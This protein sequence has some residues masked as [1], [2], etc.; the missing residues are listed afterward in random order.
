M[1][2]FSKKIPGYALASTF[3]ALGG[4]LN[5]YVFKATV[6]S[7]DI[8]RPLSLNSVLKLISLDVLEKATFFSSCAKRF[9]RG[10]Y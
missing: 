9:Y 3:V 8:F 2:F 10:W 6:L 1:H 5:G 4:V 7:L